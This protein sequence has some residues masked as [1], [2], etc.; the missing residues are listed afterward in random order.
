M[1]VQFIVDTSELAK[2][3]DKLPGQ[4]QAEADRAVSD[5]ARQTAATIRAAYRQVRS[6]SDTFTVDGKTLTRRHLA[7]AVT[8]KT[9]SKNLGRVSARVSVNAP[10]AYMFEYGTVVRSTKD[11]VSRGASPAHLTLTT[12]A[13]RERKQMVSDVIDI[14]EAAGFE[15]TRSA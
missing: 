10:H 9:T 5:A 15:V 13:M 7:D 12:S 14:V 4:L 8:T 11:G 3:I 2:A 1:P 6:D